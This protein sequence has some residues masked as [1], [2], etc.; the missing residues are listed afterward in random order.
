M[1]YL[2][3]SGTQIIR[4]VDGHLEVD[5]ISSPP[6]WENSMF[7]PLDEPGEPPSPDEIAW[8]DEHGPG[9]EQQDALE[10]AGAYDE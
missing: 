10:A 2:N 8:W 5:D 4:R 1:T 6:Y 7:D 9:L 3:P